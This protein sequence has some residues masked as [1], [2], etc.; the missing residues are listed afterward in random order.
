MYCVSKTIGVEVELDECEGG[1]KL[2]RHETI[3]SILHENEKKL[4]VDCVLKCCNPQMVVVECTATLLDTGK[5]F[6]KVGEANPS[7]LEGEISKKYPATMAYNRAIDR[8]VIAALGLPQKKVYSS[9]EIQNAKKIKNHTEEQTDSSFNNLPPFENLPFE[10]P[11]NIQPPEDSNSKKNTASQE[12]EKAESIVSEMEDATVPMQEVI[13]LFD[14][15]DDNVA[16]KTEKNESISPENNK[17]VE[18]TNDNQND[19]IL[20][21]IIRESEVSLMMLIT[22]RYLFKNCLFLPGR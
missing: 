2:I 20:P 13:S 12:N 8:A 6:F 11:D 19:E 17:K 5:T 21:S 22:L 4:K 7:N 3:E 18:N 9:E 10:E 16:D 14:E 15:P 1:I